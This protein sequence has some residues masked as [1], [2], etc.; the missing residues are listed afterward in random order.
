MTFCE[1]L[2][3]NLGTSQISLDIAPV[4]LYDSHR[5]KERGLSYA[6]MVG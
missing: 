2:N 6:K 5:Y 3:H 1:G 4:W